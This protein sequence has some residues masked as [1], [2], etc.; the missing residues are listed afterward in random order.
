[1]HSVVYDLVHQILTGRVDGGL[2]RELTLALFRDAQLMQRIVDGQKRNDL[3]KCVWDWMLVGNI[4]D[5]LILL[6]LNPK[7]FG[8]VTW[9][10]SH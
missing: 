1:M 5:L 6:A 8:S 3:E 10:T 2:N 7:E 4:S 9:D